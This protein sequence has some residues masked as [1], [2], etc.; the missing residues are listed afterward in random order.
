MPTAL[1]VRA[2]QAPAPLK[3]VGEEITILA[4]GAQTGSYEL[5]RQAGPEGTGPPPHSHPWDEAFYVIE[6]EVAFG[7]DDVQDVVAALWN[8]RARPRRI[9][10]LVPLRRRWRRDVLGDVS[11][12]TIRLLHPGRS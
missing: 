1:I 9:H 11:S 3:V 4:N 5:F 6:G 8:A 7:V 2:D 10:A 12:G